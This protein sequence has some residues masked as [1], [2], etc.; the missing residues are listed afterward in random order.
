[1][2]EQ[3]KNN[4]ILKIVRKFNVTPE[5]VFDTFTKPEMMRIWWTPQTTFD[6]DLRVGGHWKIVRKEDDT[7]F[8]ALGKYLE[9]ERP[10]KLR[11]TYAMP[12][13]SPESD[14]ISIDISA[15]SGNGCIVTF[16]ESGPGIAK[17]LQELPAG[18]ISDSEKGWQQAFDMMEAHWKSIES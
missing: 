12:Q 15:N 13:F 10:H 9:V 6:I 8:T 17:E 4:P 14:V 7:T 16:I 5:V 3:T 11:Y 2:K 18:Q 1:M